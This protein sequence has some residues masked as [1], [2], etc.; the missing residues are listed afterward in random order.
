V[1]R[2]GCWPQPAP[3]DS[4]VT[5]EVRILRLAAGGDGVGRLADGRT[6]FV[7]RSAPGDLL[8]ITRFRSYARFARAR[9]GRLVEGGPGRVE[10]RCAH[11]L[12]DDCGGCQLQHLSHDAQLEA[13]RAIVTDALERI[14]RLTF[15]VP[16]V[17]GPDDVW[18]YR[19]R[20][21]LAV[22]PDRRQAGFHPLDEP[23]RVFA[24]ERCEIA[25]PPLME[26]LRPLRTLLHLLPSDAEQLLLRLDR[27]ERLHLVVKARGETA[28][29][30]ARRLHQELSAQGVGAVIWWQPGDGAAR[31][32]AGGDETFP[33]TVFEQ[34][35]P[36]LG[37]RIRGWALD[38]LG[39]EAADHVWDLYAGIG[40][41]S[42][43]LSARGASVESVELD[44]RAVRLAAER[45]RRVAG[46]RP[47]SEQ[48]GSP[49][50]RRHVGRVED[51]VD[52]LEDPSLVVANPP[53][54]GLHPRVTAA[55]RHRRPR[56]MVYVSCDPATLARDLAGLCA[57]GDA[58]YRLTELQP[59]DLFPQ[60][61][62]V[63]TVAVLE[64]Q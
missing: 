49:R 4:H 11:Y 9:V 48:A 34:V 58:R 8:E 55:L 53:R 59:F 30:T 60:T 36:G 17:I 21:T 37:D 50:V 5:E 6:V 64:G 26:L 24:L 1:T 32:M 54:A 62:H 13:K 15:E 16:P 46:G 42:T 2:A 40:E 14:G 51:L 12:A 39:V 19:T 25:A 57:P 61:A 52:R 28:W 31:V 43:A 10:P 3:T 22:G 44:R 63:E 35:H 47:E 20:V 45:E 38:R 18:A 56:R 29:R 7:P 33:A 27:E 41:T 23:R